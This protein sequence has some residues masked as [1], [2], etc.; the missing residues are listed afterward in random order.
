MNKRLKKW[1]RRLLRCVG[2]LLLFLALYGLAA[3]VLPRIPVNAGETPATDDPV[4]VYLLTNGVHTDLVLP[5]YHELHDWSAF[6]NPVDTRSGD[7]NVR[8]AAFG[9]GDKGFYLDTPTWADL[10]FSTAFKAMFWLSTS[11]MHVTYYHELQPGEACRKLSVSRADYT[12]IVDYIERSFEHTPKGLP[13][14]IQGA[15]DE[16]DAFYEANGT[17]NLFFT[18]NTWANDG[19]KAGNQKACLWTPFQQGIFRLYAPGT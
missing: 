12:R 16:N 6:V 8:Y 10:K 19:L 5:M 15:Y 18:C 7:T 14:L 13:K 17:Y 11:A 1:A 3:V 9:W 4:V 2:G